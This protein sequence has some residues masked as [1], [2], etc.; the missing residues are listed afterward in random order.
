M[1]LYRDGPRQGLLIAKTKGDYF[2]H[3]INLN[4]HP[5]NFGNS[6]N[7]LDIFIVMGK[8]SVSKKSDS[9][10]GFQNMKFRMHFWENK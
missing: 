5:I 9:I 7:V 4:M 10:K 8:G 6:R 3:P 2:L 1:G